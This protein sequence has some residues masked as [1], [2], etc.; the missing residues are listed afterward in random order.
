MK[1]EDL[2]E[3]MPDEY[4]KLGRNVATDIKVVVLDKKGR[5]ATYKT[6]D[7]RVN[8]ETHCIEI[9]AKA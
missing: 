9:I 4:A 8:Y 5:R 7:V 6:T 3:L 1:A 2:I